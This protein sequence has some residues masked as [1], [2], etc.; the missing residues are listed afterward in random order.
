MAFAGGF[1]FVKG[2]VVE[3]DEPVAISS[4]AVTEG[5]LLTLT[6]GSTT[7]TAATSS[8]IHGQLKAVATETVT[9]SATSVKV[10]HV[11]PGQFWVA[12]LANNSAAADNGDRMVLTDANTV[13]NTGTD[14]TAKEAFFIQF[15][16]V[17][18]AAEKR[19]LGFIVYGSGVLSSAA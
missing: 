8:S 9:S 2:P 7:W 1:T 10:R 12:E 5:D 19:A 4:L 6:A 3:T 13:N 14:S 16:P 11:I 15:A 18:A 17:G